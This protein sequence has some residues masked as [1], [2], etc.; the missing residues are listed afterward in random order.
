MTRRL[1]SFRRKTRH[2][3]MKGTRQKGKISFTRY[4]QELKQGDVVCLLAEP[5]IQNGMYHP[6]FHGKS[7]EVIDQT[8]HCYKIKIDDQG[9]NK[10]LI[11]HPI[12]LKKMSVKTNG[13]V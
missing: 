9:K 8:G 10:I 5:S 1:G 6:R 13:K 7:G 11:V 2:K 12:H 4:F 3:L